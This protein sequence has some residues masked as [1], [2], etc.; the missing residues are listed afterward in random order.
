MMGNIMID[1]IQNEAARMELI[2]EKGNNKG[3][4][5]TVMLCAI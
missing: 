4:I 1:I 5:I 2:K 3:E